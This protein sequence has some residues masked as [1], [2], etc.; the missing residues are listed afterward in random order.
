MKKEKNS[1]LVVKILKNDCK[2]YIPSKY[3]ITKWAKTAFS[4]KKD[5]VVL[6]KIAKKK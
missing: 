6:I 3:K 2:G 4:G 1:L 5:S